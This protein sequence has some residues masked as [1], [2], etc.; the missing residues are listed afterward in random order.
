[1]KGST[2]PNKRLSKQKIIIFF[3]LMF[4]IIFIFILIGIFKNDSKEFVN[5][6]NQFIYSNDANDSN[7]YDVLDKLKQ[8]NSNLFNKNDN[9]KNLIIVP[10]LSSNQSIRFSEK[11]YVSKSTHLDNKISDFKNTPNTTKL[12]E[13]EM[14]KNQKNLD[15]EWM[16]AKSLVY[17]SKLDNSKIELSKTDTTKTKENEGT[18]IKETNFFANKYKSLDIEHE[19]INSD[20]V[21]A[22]SNFELKAGSIIPATMINGINSDLPGEVIAIVRENVYDSINRNFLLIPQGSRLVGLYDNNIIYGQQRLVVI[23]NKL[24]YPN[25]DSVNLKAMPGTDLTGYSGFY[26]LVDNKYWQI[27]GSSFIIGVIS[28]AMQYSQNNTNSNV[29]VGGNGVITNANPTV[30][31]T[32]AG[33]LGQQLGQTGIMITQKNLN[34]QPTIIIRSGYQFNVMMTADM[35]LKPYSSTN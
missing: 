33:S 7:I 27:F 32:L 34:V 2:L 15:S 4:S 3:V 24:I 22:K 26:D 13:V 6:D 11:D 12:T 19:N 30:G 5:N 16:Y 23:W 8:T 1:M 35:V 25:G 14:G 18:N 9:N 10:P 31:Q 21:A 29:Q 17:S 20:I 28:A